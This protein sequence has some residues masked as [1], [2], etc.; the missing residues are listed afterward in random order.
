MSATSSPPHYRQHENRYGI[1]FHLV[2]ADADVDAGDAD[3]YVVIDSLPVANDQYE[4]SHDLQGDLTGTGTHLGLNYRHA[5]PDGW[6]SYELAVEQGVTNFLKVIYFSGDAGRTFSI[7]A[8]DVLLAAVTLE[9]VNPGGFYDAYYEIP[10]ELMEGKETVTI[11]FQANS[12]SYAGGIFE[13]L[14][15]VKEK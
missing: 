9:N 5:E 11:R 6:F 14:S 4:F 8:D 2:D 1:Y 10:G 12:V 15:T 7:Y 3:K 13:K